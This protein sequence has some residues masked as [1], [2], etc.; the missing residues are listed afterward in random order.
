[1]GT[2][3]KFVSHL[4]PVRDPHTS[5]SSAVVTMSFHITC[6]VISPDGATLRAQGKDKA[7]NWQAASLDLD[8]VFGNMNG[9]F[10]AGYD[11]VSKTALNLSVATHDDGSVWLSGRL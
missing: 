11:C 9:P 6:T 5:S 3:K 4:N 8:T 1:M 10:V 2:F 7:G